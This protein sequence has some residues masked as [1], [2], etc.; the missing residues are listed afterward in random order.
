MGVYDYLKGACPKCGRKIGEKSGDIQIKWFSRPVEEEC[1]RTFYPTNRF[2]EEFPDGIYPLEECL[3]CKTMLY[4]VVKEN[5]FNGFTVSPTELPTWNP[6]WDHYNTM[7][8]IAKV[9][10]KDNLWR[11]MEDREKLIQEAEHRAKVRRDQLI[12]QGCYKPF[13]S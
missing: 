13:S 3:G 8:E 6:D 2:P 4:A 7:E 10:P 5:R 9:N 12:S 1:F 11:F